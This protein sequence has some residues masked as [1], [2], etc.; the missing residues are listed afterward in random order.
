[1]SK[2]FKD[3][4]EPIEHNKADIDG[5]YCHEC[6]RDIATGY[7]WNGYCVVC[8]ELQI[9]KKENSDFIQSLRTASQEE[10]DEEG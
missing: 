9:Q 10:Q 5:I 2:G 8:A 6:G 4:I 7:S 3:L 1:M